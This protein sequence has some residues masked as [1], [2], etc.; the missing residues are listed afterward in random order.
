MSEEN[1]SLRL[2][3]SAAVTFWDVADDPRL[4]ARDSTRG[5]VDHPAQALFAEPEAIPEDAQQHLSDESR[6]RWQ[7]LKGEE[8]ARKESKSRREKLK[9]VEMAARDR[10]IDVHRFLS[11]IDR[12]IRAMQEVV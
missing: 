8:L 4:L 9:Q 6:R 7:V 3:S 1:V 2:A 12:Q 10:H 11:E 5:Y